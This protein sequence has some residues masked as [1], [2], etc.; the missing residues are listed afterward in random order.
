MGD[1]LLLESPSVVQATK[2]VLA[3]QKDMAERN[4]G[5]DEDRQIICRIGVHLGDVV[6][7]RDYIFGDGINIAV[8][9]ESIC[10]PG[11]V[12]ISGTAYENI[13]GRVETGFV[14]GGDQE[15][16]N[17]ARPVRV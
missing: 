6:V 16:N 1:G 14:D 7:E 5:V 12:A 3:V 4:A 8:R 11:G 13:A 15:Q 17:I 2:C 10:E 9:L